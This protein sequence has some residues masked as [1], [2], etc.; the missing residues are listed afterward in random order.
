[1]KVDSFTAVGKFCIPV[2]QAKFVTIVQF[3]SGEH[4]K[5]EA[6]DFCFWRMRYKVPIGKV[7]GR[8][9]RASIFFPPG[10]RFCRLEKECKAIWIDEMKE[11]EN[12]AFIRPANRA[13]VFRW[14]ET[15]PRDAPFA[16]R[17]ILGGKVINL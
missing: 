10:E 5:R 17:L 12:I 15:H 8:I 4:G 1:M 14:L 13:E 9:G 3:N 7:K 16:Y 11:G 6:G 2:R